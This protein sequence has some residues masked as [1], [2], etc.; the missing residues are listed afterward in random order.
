MEVDIACGSEVSVSVSVAISFSLR[1]GGGLARRWDDLIRLM[2]MFVWNEL[3][4][5]AW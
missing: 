4:I 2:L 5:T 1:R 3:L